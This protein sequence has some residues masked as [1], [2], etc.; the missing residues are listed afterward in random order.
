MG[1]L[2]PAY[3]AFA[4]QPAEIGIVPDFE[5]SKNRPISDTIIKGI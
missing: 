2:A 5:T 4:Q 3:V 1:D